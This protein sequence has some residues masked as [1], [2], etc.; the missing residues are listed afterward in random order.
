MLALMASTWATNV[1]ELSTF[2]GSSP[3]AAVS[4]PATEAEKHKAQSQTVIAARVRFHGM[5]PVLAR[6]FISL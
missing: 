3:A 1:R 2:F 5:P 4:R 6:Y